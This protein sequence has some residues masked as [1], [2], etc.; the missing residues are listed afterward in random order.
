MDFD[1]AR[2]IGAQAFLDGLP[3]VPAL[4]IGFIEAACASGT[5]TVDL[6][7]AFNNGWTIAYLAKDSP[8]EM[9]SVIEFKR[10]MAVEN[11][12]DEKG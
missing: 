2:K 7:K 3:V 9:P 12:Q 4:N 6:L 10:L 1:Q 11:P 8:D 5:P